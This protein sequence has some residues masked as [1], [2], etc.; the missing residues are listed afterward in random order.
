MHGLEALLGYAG[1][2]PGQEF[3]PY[4]MAFLAWAAAAVGAVLVWPV[5]A[6]LR[7]LRKSGAVSPAGEKVQARG[8]DPGVDL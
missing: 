6:L 3:I 7:R 2:G 4:F 8:S 5:A 1:L